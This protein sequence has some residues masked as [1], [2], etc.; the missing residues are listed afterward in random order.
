[1]DA[2]DKQIAE[3]RQRVAELEALLQAALAENRQLKERI[4][5]PEKN[6]RNSSKPPSSDIVKPPKN[7]N[8]QKKVSVHGLVCNSALT[9][10]VLVLVLLASAACS[11]MA[12]TPDS[13]Q[14][15]PRCLQ[16]SETATSFH[17]STR[18][19]AIHKPNAWRLS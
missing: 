6:S 13:V 12:K 2:K 5:Q 14:L 10:A 8:G 18:V 1:M 3:L 9:W 15:I 11:A 19:L 16:R 7:K 17:L 4:A